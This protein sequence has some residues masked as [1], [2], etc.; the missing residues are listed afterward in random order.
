MF[1]SMLLIYVISVIFCLVHAYGE[2][3]ANFGKAETLWMFIVVSFAPL[4]NTIYVLMILGTHC[5]PNYIAETEEEKLETFFLLKK[6]MNRVEKCKSC[7][8][9]SYY[10]RIL[11]NRGKCPFCDSPSTVPVKEEAPISLK[12]KFFEQISIARK[13]TRENVAY[14]KGKLKKMKEE[15]RVATEMKNAE[16]EMKAIEFKDDQ[17]DLYLKLQEQKISKMNKERRE[18]EKTSNSL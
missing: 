2:H 14:S 9:N 15:D 1:S 18:N 16:E 17:L 8:I 4:L 6:K 5:R 3:L 12:I 10:G 11:L 7:Q 13:I